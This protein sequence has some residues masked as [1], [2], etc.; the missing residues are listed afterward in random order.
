V[1]GNLFRNFSSQLASIPS[2]DGFREL[3][4]LGQGTHNFI[5]AMIAVVL[6]M[7]L[8]HAGK[9]QPLITRPAAVRWLAYYATVMIISFY[10]VFD[11]TTKFIYFQF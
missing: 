11:N 10:G 3:I 8:A 2:R 9:Q 7:F 1:V 5:V 6:L 4:C